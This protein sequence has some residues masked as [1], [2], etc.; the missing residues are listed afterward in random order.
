VNAENAIEAAHQRTYARTG[1][2]KT[3]KAGPKINVPQHTSLSAP[4]NALKPFFPNLGRQQR[5]QMVKNAKKKG[6]GYTK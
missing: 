4:S 5:R 3:V 6:K 2:G 1:K